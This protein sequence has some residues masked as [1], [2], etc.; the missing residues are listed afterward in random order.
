MKLL[1]KIFPTIKITGKIEWPILISLQDPCNCKMQREKG[2][3]M[4]LRVLP[5]ENFLKFKKKFLV[6]VKFIF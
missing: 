4:C 6:T 5:I 2:K 1:K 3:L